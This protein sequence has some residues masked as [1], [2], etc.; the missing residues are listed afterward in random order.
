MGA[1]VGC[2]VAS[3]SYTFPGTLTA[4]MSFNT[5]IACIMMSILLLEKI[6]CGGCGNLHG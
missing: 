6:R 4:I 2:G 5:A 3:M 1:F